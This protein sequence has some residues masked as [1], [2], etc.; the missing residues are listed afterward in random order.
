MKDKFRK[1]LK[2]NGHNQRTVAKAIRVDEVC[3]SRWVNGKVQPTVF[4]L[5]LLSD[6]LN[7][8]MD[9][10]YNIFYV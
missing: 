9:N 4:N 2:K 7:V 8:S 6:E 3:I 5:K 1:L 10:L